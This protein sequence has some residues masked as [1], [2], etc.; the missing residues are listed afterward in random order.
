M[1]RAQERAYHVMAALA[2]NLTGFEEASRALF[3]GDRDR[4]FHLM[5]RWPDDVREHVGRLADPDYEVAP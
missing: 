3:A 1:R 4:L 2:G 5:A